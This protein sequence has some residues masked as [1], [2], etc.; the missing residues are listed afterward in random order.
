M[1]I[2]GSV[3][4]VFIHLLI[5]CSPVFALTPEKIAS[6]AIPSIVLIETPDG[7]GTGFVVSKNGLIA[8]NLHVIGTSKKATVILNDETRYDQVEVVNYDW[9]YDLILLKIPSNKLKPLSLGNSDKVKVGQGVVAIG[10]PLGFG[11]TVSDGLV[12]AVRDIEPDLRLIQVSAPI[13]PGSSGGPLFNDAGKVIGISA[14]VAEGG[15]NLNFGIPINQLKSMIQKGDG[16]ALENWQPSE[17]AN[18][19]DAPEYDL[20]ILEGCTNEQLTEIWSSI[21]NAISLGAPLYNQGNHEACY[22]IYESAAQSLSGK[23]WSC[24]GPS[25]I[26]SQGITAAEQLPEW[27][28]K[29]WAIRGAFDNVTNLVKHSF[30][31]SNNSA[32]QSLPSGQEI[33]QLPLSS[34][35][36]CEQ[37]DIQLI[38]NS[39]ANAIKV[40]APLYN[41]GN[42]EACYRVYEGAIFN[43]ENK[44]QACK[45]P[46]ETLLEGMDNAG[47]LYDFTDKAWAIRNAFDGVIDVINRYEENNSNSNN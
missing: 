38:I 28:D 43:V 27:T 2:L 3:S 6:K 10:H 44:I 31:E 20:T 18:S 11:N 8:T 12:S 4:F 25:Q 37:E 15:Q 13:S 45:K 5:F 30:T 7:Y 19:A 24:A 14:L 21:G 42:Y 29:A 39:I 47:K 34:L 33:P 22:R 32:A 9:D 26:L 35:A 17:F 23:S 46:V 36:D 41:Q 1:R 16:I 40:G